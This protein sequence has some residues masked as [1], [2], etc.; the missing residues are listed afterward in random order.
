MFL[1]TVDK[2]LLLLIDSLAAHAETAETFYL[3]GGTGLALRLGHRTSIDI[4]LF[5]QE[6][7]NSERYVSLI[8]GLNA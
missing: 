5:S 8:I 2:Q 1:N 6:T 4:D 7:F 3:A